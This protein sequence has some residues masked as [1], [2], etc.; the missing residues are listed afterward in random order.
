LR[1]VPGRKTI[2]GWTA[3]PVWEQR[4]VIYAA[5][6]SIRQ[7]NEAADTSTCNRQTT[8]EPVDTFRP[9]SLNNTPNYEN[10][11]ESVNPR[12][13]GACQTVTIELFNPFSV[14]SENTI[15]GD[16]YVLEMRHLRKR[17]FGW[18][19]GQSFNQAHKTRLEAEP[20]V[21]ENPC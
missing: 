1:P 3:V 6:I 7:F 20:S 17:S 12:P 15:L 16:K 18:K 11:D 14:K 13:A 2:P 4:A 5:I 9:R 19:S 10:L 8:S 21:G